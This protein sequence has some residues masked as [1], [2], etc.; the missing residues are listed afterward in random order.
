VAGRIVPTEN[1][2]CVTW[3][4]LFMALLVAVWPC[5]AMSKPTRVV[6]MNLCTDQLA[7]LLAGEGQLHSVSYFSTRPDVSM[8]ARE[9]SRFVVNSA[10][11]EEIYLMRPDLVLASPFTRSSSV[12]MLR[13][14]GVR[15]ETFAPSETFPAIREAIQRMGR[16]LHQNKSAERV[17]AT[18]ERQIGALVDRSGPRPRAAIYSANS[19]TFGRGTLL[20]EIFRLAGVENIGATL[21][22]AGSAKFPL[23]VL[24]MSTPDLVVGAQSGDGETSKSYE[25]LSHPA[26]AQ[27]KQESGSVILADKYWIC[28]TPFTLEAV[29]RLVEAARQ[30][31]I[32]DRMRR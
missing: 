12:A 28:G 21:G 7:L 16:L 11:A 17:V 13:R 30:V 20:D 27:I 15:V 1:R 3:R 23:E 22:Y 31:P 10:R 29:R 9:A 8:L 26:F 25:I 18:F 19:Y 32:S 14:L 5:A 24:V 6:S 4:A 2:L